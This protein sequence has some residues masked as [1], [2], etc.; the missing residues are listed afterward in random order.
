MSERVEKKNRKQKTDE[1]ELS[2]ACNAIE[3]FWTVQR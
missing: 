2:S 1:S 3:A